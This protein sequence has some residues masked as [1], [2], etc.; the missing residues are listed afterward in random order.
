MWSHDS[1]QDLKTTTLSFPGGQDIFWSSTSLC[2]SVTA[3]FGVVWKARLLALM[4]RGF[5]SS[6]TSGERKKRALL[7]SPSAYTWCHYTI[8]MLL[9]F[10]PETPFPFSHFM[11]WEHFWHY[12]LLHL[13]SADNSEPE[14]TLGLDLKLFTGK[15]KSRVLHLYFNVWGTI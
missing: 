15:R 7:L 13:C 12:T 4:E 5:L 11:L 8:N 1:Q 3:A 2:F 6:L 10:S 9:P 14:A